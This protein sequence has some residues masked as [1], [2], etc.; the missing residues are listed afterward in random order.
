MAHT[1][2]L[3]IGFVLSMLSFFCK[4]DKENIV[5]H[6]DDGVNSDCL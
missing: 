3:I 6:E 5:V 4:P 1:T 2:L